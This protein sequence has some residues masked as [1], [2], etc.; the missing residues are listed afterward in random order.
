[1]RLK[2]P[3]T[4]AAALVGLP[5]LGLAAGL[6]VQI[7]LPRLNVSEYHRPYVAAWIEHASGEVGANLVVWHD[8]NMG[9]EEG[10]KWLRELRQWWRR[11]GRE[12]RMPAD[13]VSGAT[14]PPGSH[15]L[16]FSEGKAPLPQ[17]LKPGSYRLVVEAA[18]EQGERE[19]V[20]LP[21]EWP[22]GK[23][24]QATSRGIT[25]LGEV[26]LELKP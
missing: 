18:R 1:M 14:R 22:P 12:M 2:Y 10:G 17:Q 4:L 24:S 25:E 7:Q 21:F 15:R 5:P 16:Q 13:G 26:T 23:A 3:S 6:D 11:S 8:Q 19:V 9:I 20:Q